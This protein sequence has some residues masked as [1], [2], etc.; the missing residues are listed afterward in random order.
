VDKN[1]HR[2]HRGKCSRQQ[3]GRRERPHRAQ[4]DVQCLRHATTNALNPYGDFGMHHTDSAHQGRQRNRRSIELRPR[5]RGN[6]EDDG[7]QLHQQHGHD[8]SG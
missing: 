3:D 4:V 8:D 7:G 6:D 1:D 2:D 5:K